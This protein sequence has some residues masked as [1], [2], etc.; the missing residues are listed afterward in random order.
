VRVQQDGDTALS[1]LLEQL[2][3]GAAAGG[4]ERARRLVEEQ[5]I[6]RAD[7]GLREAEPLLH[8]LGHRLDRAFRRILQADEAEE[9]LSFRRAAVGAGEALVEGEELDRRVPAWETE[10]LG[11]ISERAACLRGERWLTVDGRLAGRGTDEAA[12]DLDERRLAGAVRPE[13]AHELALVDLEVDALQRLDRAVLLR[14]A[15]DG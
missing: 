10:E 2:A 7:E 6:G 15:P 1:Q 13:Q 14:K 9:S 12:R 3:D 5:E 4:I 8:A 11:E